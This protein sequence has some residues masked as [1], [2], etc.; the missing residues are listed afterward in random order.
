MKK[1]AIII[2]SLSGNSKLANENMLKSVFGE[3]YE[4]ETIKINN[5]NTFASLDGYDRIIACGG[6]G[7]INSVINSAHKPHAE[8]IY[9]PFGTLNE[10]GSEKGTDAVFKINNIN[11]AGSKM[12]TYVF[13]AGIFTPLG[14]IVKT[15]DKK[16]FK[17]LAYI[18]KV[19][20][21]YKIYNIKADISTDKASES[22]EYTLIMAIDS[23][24]C[25][26][27]K[28][29][30][31]YCRNDNKFHLLTIKSP[32]H[33]GFLGKAEIFFPLF[34]AFFIGFGKE[35]RSKNMRF[36]AADTLNL[37]LND[38]VPFC[39]DGEKMN[40]S[41]DFTIGTAPVEPAITVI[42]A[43]MLK[44]L[45]KEQKSFDKYAAEKRFDFTPNFD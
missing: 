22:G 31:L 7:T 10:F 45:Y 23:P 32:R 20:S 9:C 28:F 27:F 21:Q 15:K 44:K 4:V 19:I 5:D 40:F 25:F 36:V 30:R 14:Y 16:R 34:K 13:A 26:G 1:C 35:Y 12:F 3:N 6:D 37:K 11:N 29:N 43:K 42:T 33:K 39:V 18:S 2:N 17:A 24:R 8:I 41:G 38:T